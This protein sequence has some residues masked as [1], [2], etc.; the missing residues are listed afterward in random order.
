MHP[1]V[2]QP[3]MTKSGTTSSTIESVRPDHWVIGLLDKAGKRQPDERDDF[4]LDTRKS[5]ALI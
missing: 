3:E 2:S 4:E 5:E 1:F